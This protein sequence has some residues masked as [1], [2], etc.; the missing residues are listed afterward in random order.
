MPPPALPVWLA[1]ALYLVAG[2]RTEPEAP[3]DAVPTPA[4]PPPST[5]APGVLYGRVVTHGG[6]V[7]EG[8]LRWG[9]GE[10]AFW[11]DTFDGVKAENPWAA[12]VPPG[13]IE[14]ATRRATVL[15]VPVPWAEPEVDLTRPFRAR[16]GDLA[17]VESVGDG[18]RGV[19]EDRAAFAPVVRVTLKGGAA[20]DLDRLA[21]GDFDDGVRVWDRELGVVDLDAREV[22]AVEFLPAPRLRGAPDRLRGTVRAGGRD[23]SG[24]VQWDRGHSTGA[25]ALVG[26]AAE[27]ERRVPFGDV[28]SVVRDGDGVRVALR[29]GRVLALSGTRAT[30]RGFRGVAV[31][32][33]RY[34]R[35]LVPWAAFERADFDRPARPAAG[36]P[37]YG[38]FRPGRPL[39]GTVTD[40]AGR[41][42]AGRLVFDLDESVTT[43]T[44]DAPA[45]GVDVS[46]PFGRVA[47]VALPDGG[48]PAVVTLA[49][50]GALTLDRS[51]DLGDGNAG[52]LVFAAGRGRP[53]YVRWADVARIDFDGAPGGRR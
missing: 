36:G 33:P 28:R 14:G 32:D 17:R 8:R 1:V 47:S 9:G 44:L 18:V 34:G 31:D 46:V 29:G 2:C 40:R 53:E 25:D 30:G 3:T 48:G 26:R 41:R 52:V 12:L 22:R 6:A 21:S 35:V 24:F 10:E 11:T 43:E 5:E 38:D 7:Y 50:G 16:F 45:G 37:A 49:D 51:G 13:E 42:R 27:G 39:A 19:V 20:V 23:Y 15:G 4:A